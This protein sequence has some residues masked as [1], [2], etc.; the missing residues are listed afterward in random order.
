MAAEITVQ[1]IVPSGYTPGD[2]ALLCSNGGEGAIDWDNPLPGHR[3]DLF[4]GGVGIYGYG[5]APY[6]NFRYGSAHSSPQAKGYGQLPYG[7]FPYGFGAVQITAITQVTVCGDYKFGFACYDDAGN[8]H[9]GTP[10]EAAAEIH[11]APPA[12]GGLKFSSYDPD[13]DILVLAVA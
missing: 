7:H 13:T 6:G 2:Y 4:P 8:R 1:F 9:A 5:H 10:D 12:P 11:I 3:Y